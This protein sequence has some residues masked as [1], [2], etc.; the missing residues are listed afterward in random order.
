MR[1]EVWGSEFR[2]RGLTF[3]HG[4][5]LEPAD[6]SGK[7]QMGRRGLPPHLVQD[8][9]FGV[10]VYGLGFRVVLGFRV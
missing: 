3:W 4:R 6:V 1:F 7:D 9:G 2:G 10:R 5:A 8:L